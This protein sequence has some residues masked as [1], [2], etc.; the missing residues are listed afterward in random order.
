MTK[1]CI[2]QSANDDERTSAADK[3]KAA[4]PVG[5]YFLNAIF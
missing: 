4:D 3:S 5:Q 1:G 2:Y